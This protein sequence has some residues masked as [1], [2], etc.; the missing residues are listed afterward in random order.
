MRIGLLGAIVA[1]FIAAGCAAPRALD[2]A[3]VGQIEQAFAS[4]IAK[5]KIPGAV[6]LVARDGK[7]AYEKALGVQDPVT[8]APMRTDSIFRVYSM[9]K[10]VVSVVAMQ[11]VEE[12]RIRLDD[13]V[14]Q[15]FRCRD[16]PGVVGDERR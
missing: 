9:T 15:L 11:L 12:G 5:K 2:T 14:A 8:G 7:V 1:S 10:P 3:R 6:M 4:E 13:S 16:H